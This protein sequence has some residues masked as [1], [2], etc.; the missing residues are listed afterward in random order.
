MWMKTCLLYTR[1][2]VFIKT[3]LIDQ[4]YSVQDNGIRVNTGGKIEFA[5]EGRA[6]G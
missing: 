2:E 3:L 5:E 4:L 1:K 6:P